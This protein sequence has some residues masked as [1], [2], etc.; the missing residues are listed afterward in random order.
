MTFPEKIKKL[1]KEKGLTQ[2]ELAKN[3]FVSRTL[4]TKYEN[5]SVYPTKENAE[6]LALFFGVDLSELIDSN[7]TVQLILKQ[8]ELSSKINLILNSIIISISSLLSIIS[9]LPIVRI[10]Y[11]D[12]SNGV[13]PELLY[14]YTYSFDITLSNGNPI[15]LITFILLIS[16]IVLSVLAIKFKQNTWIKLINYS[17]FI[18]NIFLIFISIVFIVSY[19]S[20]NLYDF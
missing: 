5:G 20:S 19:S 17:L 1:R 6:K 2:E 8:N 3:I 10:S 12:Y 4:I 9:F 13:P 16:N 7:D 11:Y 14:K 15:V 18:L